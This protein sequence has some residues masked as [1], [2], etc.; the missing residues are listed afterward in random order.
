M[1]RIILVLLFIF[2]MS[3]F[4]LIIR[5]II[6]EYKENKKKQNDFLRDLENLAEIIK[7]REKDA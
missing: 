4:I 5:K 2:L 3:I 1:I 6:M 7:N